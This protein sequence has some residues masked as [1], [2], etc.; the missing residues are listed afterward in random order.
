MTVR[1]KAEALEFEASQGGCFEPLG[2]LTRLEKVGESRAWVAHVAA[3][4]GR[5]V[6]GRVCAM[7]K[8]EEPVRN[9]QEGSRKHARKKG[10][11]CSRR[12]G[13]SLGT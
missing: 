9:A 2:R 1:V 12:H 5:L 4:Q 8:M 6:E 7:R 13:L 10:R 11:R 3:P